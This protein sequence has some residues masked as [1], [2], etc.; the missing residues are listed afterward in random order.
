MAYFGCSIGT[1]RIISGGYSN[2]SGSWPFAWRM[3]GTTSKR[4]YFGF[5]PSSMHNCKKRK[6]ISFLKFSPLLTLWGKFSVLKV[7]FPLKQDQEM[8]FKYRLCP[9]LNRS[10][11]SLCSEMEGSISL[12]RKKLLLQPET[13]IC[14]AGNRKFPPILQKKKKEKKKPGWVKQDRKQLWFC[15]WNYTFVN[16]TLAGSP[17]TDPSGIWYPAYRMS[18]L[19]QTRKSCFP[20]VLWGKMVMAD[21]LREMIKPNYI[22]AA[23]QTHS[24]Y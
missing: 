7:V 6:W 24:D 19:F 12:D 14:G 3:S 2:I 22:T 1:S 15:I 11:S 10:F 8:P 21:L 18:W 4:P 17:M 20:S 23:H 13:R 16:S 5:H 9:R